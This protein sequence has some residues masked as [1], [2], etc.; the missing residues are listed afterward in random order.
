MVKPDAP[1]PVVPEHSPVRTGFFLLGVAWAAWL[2]GLARG[3]WINSYFVGPGYDVSDSLG[4][5]GYVADRLLAFDA[6]ALVAGVA[7]GVALTGASRTSGWAVLA[8]VLLVPSVMLH[9]LV[10][11]VHLVVA[12]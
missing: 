4:R 1:A 12:G 11:L 6:A 10:F 2:L 5:A 3:A 7:A 8:W 9:G